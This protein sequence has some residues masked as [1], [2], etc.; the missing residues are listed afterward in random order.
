MRKLRLWLVFVVEGPSLG[1]R[2]RKDVILSRYVSYFGRGICRRIIR[3]LQLVSETLGRILKVSDPLP[4]TL[5][6]LRQLLRSDEN[7][8][9]DEDNE[10]LAEPK[11]EH[12]YF[13]GAGSAKIAAAAPPM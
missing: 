10:E 11:S 13:F 1:L 6:E 7:Q 9:D 4:E 3:I 2:R 12:D 5:R 8:S